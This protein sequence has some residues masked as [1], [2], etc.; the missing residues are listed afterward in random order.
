MGANE[1]IPAEPGKLALHLNDRP[2][3]VIDEVFELAA[4]DWRADVTESGKFSYLYSQLDDRT[5]EELVQ[6]ASAV[7]ERPASQDSV[8]GMF[9]LFLSHS[10]AQREIAGGLRQALQKYQVDAFVAHDTIEFDHDWRDVIVER[11]RTCSAM[12]AIVS[13]EFASSDWCDQEVGWSQGRGIPVMSIDAGKAPY[14]FFGSRQALPFRGDLAEL[15]VSVSDRL[16]QLESTGLQMTAALVTALESASSYDQA[17]GLINL[18]EAATKWDSGLL[19]RA[20][21]TPQFNDQVLHA[22]WSQAKARL[23]RAISAVRASG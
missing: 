5:P 10:T 3:P 15:A 7:A 6:L 11:L 23:A 22:D 12:L 21:R 16:L 18:L 9:D 17:S 13:P 19:R 8:A 1:P 20:E 14:G 2:W 4:L